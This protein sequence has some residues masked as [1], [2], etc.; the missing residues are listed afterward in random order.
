MKDIENRLKDK[1]IYIEITDRAKD[2]I[3]REGYDPVYGARPLKR[4]MENVLETS[5]AKKIIKGDIYE[6]CKIRVDYDNDK[7]EIERI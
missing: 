2:V 4:Y 3:A 5:I 7:F 1:N 6:G